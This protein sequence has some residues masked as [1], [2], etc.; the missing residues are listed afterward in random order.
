M[1]EPNALLTATYLTTEEDYRNYRMAVRR[2][3][4]GKLN[5]VLLLLAG[6][7]MMAAGAA[8]LYFRSGGLYD[9]IA[10]CALIVI[11]MFCASYYDVFVPYLTRRQANAEFAL[12][13]RIL[14]AQNITLYPG[15]FAVNTDRYTATV[16][17]GLLYQCVE[18]STMFLFYTGM[19]EVRFLP[20]RVLGE[21]EAEQ[22]SRVLKAAL[23]DRYR[24]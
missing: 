12:R 7:L 15:R 23:K 10:W 3:R 2:L 14:V 13:R 4:I 17:Y 5:R 9:N 20:K 19:D 1:P 22:V 16:P 21:G 6:I 18:D 24:G 8:L 11:G